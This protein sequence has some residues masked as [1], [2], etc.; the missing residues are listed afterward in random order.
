[1]TITL[2]HQRPDEISNWLP[3]PEGPYILGMRV[4]EGH[5]EVVAC[6][7]FPAALVAN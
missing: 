6:E 7:W 5:D 3:V 2:S 4:Y 1:M